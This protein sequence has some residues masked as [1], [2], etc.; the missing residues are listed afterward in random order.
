MDL[1]S[2][3]K[4][5][6]NKAAAF[7][8][9]GPARAFSNLICCGGVEVDM[10]GLLRHGRQ[11]VE[12]QAD[13]KKPEN[14]DVHDDAPFNRRGKQ[15]EDTIQPLTPQTIKRNVWRMVFVLYE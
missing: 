3:F 2:R 9:K 1:T 7:M 8:N 4:T 14:R 15:L 5:V 11:G 12:F 13:G 6:N 10:D